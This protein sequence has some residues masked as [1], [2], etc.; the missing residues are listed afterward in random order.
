MVG[1]GGRVGSTSNASTGG[2]R[3][4]NN[5]NKGDKSARG[6]APK[7]GA[8]ASNTLEGASLPS[9]SKNSKQKQIELHPTTDASSSSKKR[10][11]RD[12]N[13]AEDDE[14][15]D[16]TITAA[17]EASED[18]EDEDDEDEDDEEDDD[19]PLV[20]ETLLLQNGN[21]SG[22]NSSSASLQSRAKKAAKYANE[23]QIE[24]DG[25]TTF[26]GNVPVIC[27]TNKVS[28]SFH[29]LLFVSFFVTL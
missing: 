3:G 18:E 10:R 9:T 25:R 12:S 28:F 17:L 22:K 15:A 23:T 1:A 7:D 16:A 19:R 2:K 24:R 13:T 6:C 8:S 4:A 29:F 21:A 27:A 26:I 20:H 14:D 11:R 5:R